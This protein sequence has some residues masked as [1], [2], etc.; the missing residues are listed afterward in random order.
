MHVSVFF[1]M[2]PSKM[3]FNVRMGNRIAIS[4]ALAIVAFY[5]YTY[6]IRVCVCVH[7]WYRCRK[8]R[9]HAKR[10]GEPE[11]RLTKKVKLISA[12]A[13]P[14]KIGISLCQFMYTFWQDSYRNQI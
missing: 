3:Y 1:M 9:L 8:S 5:L 2:Y 13:Q 12:N 11:K 10:T 7:V 4:H 6:S 14:N